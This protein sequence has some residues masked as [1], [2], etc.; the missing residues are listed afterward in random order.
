MP[1]YIIDKILGYAR[2]LR[3]F[4]L[5][6]IIILL[7]TAPL[8]A[9]LIFHLQITLK[10]WVINLTPVKLPILGYVLGREYNFVPAFG[11]DAIGVIIWLFLF[12]LLRI[13]FDKLGN[14][15]YFWLSKRQKKYSVD[16]RKID[17]NNFSKSWILQGSPSLDKEGLV[18]TN[19]NSGCLIRPR[20]PWIFTKHFMKWGNFRSRI[21]V[22]FPEVFQEVSIWS[23]PILSGNGYIKELHN[24][25][26]E[27]RKVL[28]VIFCAQ[29][30]EDYYMIEIWKVND[31]LSIRPHVRMLGNWDAPIHNS[32][33]TFTLKPKQSSVNL[34]LAV[35]NAVAKLRVNKSDFFEWALPTK[36][37]ANLIQHAKTSKSDTDLGDAAIVDIPF[38]NKPGM[39]GFRNYGNEL[40]IVK[41]L[42]IKSVT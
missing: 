14:K 15:Y 18:F 3:I 1:Q 9:I 27:F 42:T 34:E 6:S 16:F 33:L 4:K 41:K 39:F 25:R 36:F 11:A 13:F 26:E 30:L 37:E 23:E 35:E 8:S 29:S 19:S 5:G 32:P 40:A 20:F 21:E 10:E 38:R 31:I 28:G 22:E 2:T 12:W 7:F 24:V 17:S